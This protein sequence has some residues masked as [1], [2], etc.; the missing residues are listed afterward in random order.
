LVTVIVPETAHVLAGDRG[1]TVERFTVMPEG[2][3]CIVAFTVVVALAVTLIGV[4]GW[5]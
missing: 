2:I 5:L 4:P 3:G 1:G